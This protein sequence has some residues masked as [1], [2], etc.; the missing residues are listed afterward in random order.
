MTRR[1]ADY[2]DAR[3]DPAVLRAAGF[4]GV[5]RYLSAYDPARPHSK[6]LTVG[7]L[8]ALI[9]GGLDIAVVWETTA[10]RTSSGPAAGATDA[11]AANA[12]ATTL[13]MPASRPIYMAT[14]GNIFDATILGYYLAAKDASPRPIRPYGNTA[15][16]DACAANGMGGG[17]KVQTWGPPTANA[18][19]QQMPNVA[20]PVSGTDVNDVLAAD[21]GQWTAP[22]A[23][24]TT[25][26]ETMHIALDDTDGTY[27]L[28]RG[29]VVTRQFTGAPGAF[30]IP[31]DAL[32][33]SGG[34]LLLRKEPH[35]EIVD[36]RTRAANALISPGTTVEVPVQADQAKLDA[37]KNAAAN[38]ANAVAQL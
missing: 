17:W 9:A 13:G 8:R 20:T 16:V 24:P 1:V 12:Q 28:W 11:R 23:A 35:Q 36:A 7:E 31:Q 5:V 32:D 27:W 4:L 30:G 18:S 26:D 10:N 34:A 38:L 22:T 14:D 2:S 15:L 29:D 6:D 19:L 37:V 21:W 25:G 33:Y 3:P